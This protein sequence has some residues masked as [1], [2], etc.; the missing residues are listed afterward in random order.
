MSSIKRP[1]HGAL[2]WTDRLQADLVEPEVPAIIKDENGQEDETGLI[3]RSAVDNDLEFIVEPWPA[4]PYTNT[5]QVGWRLEGSPFEAVD[6][7]AYFHPVFDPVDPQPKIMK[8]PFRWLEHGTYELSYK[9]IVLG[10]DVE[11]LKKKVTIDRRPPNDGQTP[12]APGFPDEVEQAG[13]IT[14]DYLNT[15]TEVIMTVPRYT[16]MRAK[17]KIIYYWTDLNPPPSNEMPV[18][19]KV[20]SQ[21][22]IDNGNLTF[23]FASSFIRSTGQGQRFAYY[24]LRDLAGN[25]GPIGTVA[26]IEVSL[27]PAPGNLRPPRIPL[28]AR[29]LI[30][31]EHAREG[32][33][34]EGGVTVE[35]DAY[36]NPDSSHEVLVTWDGTLLSEIDVDPAGFPL[37]AYVP[38]PVLTANGLG[39]LDVQVSYQVRY[40]TVLTPPSAT[41]M[42]PINLT[43]AGQDH[44]NAPALLNMT[45][46]KLEVRGKQSNLP[47][48]LTALDHGLDATA[49]LTLYDNPE[50]L[51][52][53]EVYWGDIAQPVAGYTVA[54]GDNTGK[55]VTFEIPWSAIEQDMD[56]Q[57][58]PVYYTTDNG[59][60]QQLS[61]VTDRHGKGPR[62]GDRLAAVQAFGRDAVGLDCQ[63]RRVIPPV[64]IRRRH[65]TQR[66]RTIEDLY[67]LVLCRR[68]GDGHV[69]EVGRAA[70][71][72][73]AFGV[74]HRIDGRHYRIIKS[75]EC[76]SRNRELDGRRLHRRSIKCHVAYDCQWRVMGQ[77]LQ[78]SPGHL[79]VQP[80]SD[81]AC[82]YRHASQQV[83]GHG[84]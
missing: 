81:L 75:L 69:G 34:N 7:Y 62:I 20:F 23:S 60:N 24:R 49:T 55:I 42:A 21:D 4:E 78:L 2:N 45:L 26:A 56:N 46:A 9:I 13:V 48:Q 6:E 38:W 44:A 54:A 3:P 65:S 14:D 5:V 83:N 59:V 47:N 77:L 72:N 17:D 1:P 12:N 76:V 35:I 51:E 74:R 67:L 15:N 82:G 80:I 73:V 41:A 50:A 52:V 84:P 57:A 19:E 36:D 11:S 32:A 40:G 43:I 68:T 25:E 70:V 28:S 66:G 18:G 22:D 27:T 31:R 64:T 29:G 30:D 61:R 10:N 79:F 33:T 71:G 39:P 58:L 63:P 8:V 37:R 16:D 53:L